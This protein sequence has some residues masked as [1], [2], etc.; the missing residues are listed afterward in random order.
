MWDSNNMQ[1]YSSVFPWEKMVVV[2]TVTSG[3]LIFKFFDGSF[4]VSRSVGADLLTLHVLQSLGILED[5][6]HFWCA[7]RVWYPAQVS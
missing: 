6:T 5:G 7:A 3:S 4:V 1:R 2:K